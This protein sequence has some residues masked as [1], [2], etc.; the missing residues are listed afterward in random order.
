[1]MAASIVTVFW[2]I[3][4]FSLDC[5][6]LVFGTSNGMR[7]ISLESVSCTRELHLIDVRAERN[8]RFAVTDS[9]IDRNVTLRERERERALLRLQFLAAAC[10]ASC[11]VEHCRVPLTI[12]LAPL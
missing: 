12:C 8:C 9:A 3:F 11:S 4:L 1:M 10:R 2:L 5:P 6:H 7:V